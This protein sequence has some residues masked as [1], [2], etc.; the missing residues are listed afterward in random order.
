MQVYMLA[1]EPHAPLKSAV[2]PSVL[3]EI[4]GQGGVPPVRVRPAVR[5]HVLISAEDFRLLRLNR[6]PQERQETAPDHKSCFALHSISPD[7]KFASA[8]SRFSSFSCFQL[9]SFPFGISQELNF[10]T[11]MSLHRFE[12]ILV[13][14]LVRAED[15]PGSI[16]IRVRELPAA[17]ARPSG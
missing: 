9:S 3:F 10:L 4:S 7:L 13:F 2:I 11:R 1:L 6:T 8:V 14:L 12:N 16:T 5:T 17:T 15:D